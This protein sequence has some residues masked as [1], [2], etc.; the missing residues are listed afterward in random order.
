MTHMQL[1]IPFN[2]PQLVFSLESTP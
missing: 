1:L 2:M